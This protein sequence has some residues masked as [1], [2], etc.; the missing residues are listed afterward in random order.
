M[1]ELDLGKQV[2]PLPLGAWVVVVGAGL[3]IAVYTRRSTSTPDVPYI[4]TSGDPSVGTGPGWV[5]VPPPTTGPATQPITTNEDWARAAINHLIAKGY[6][7]NAAD[8]AI[9]G[10]IYGGSPGIRDYALLN[11]AIAALG[12]PP[13]P[14]PPATNNPPTA[15]PPSTTAPRQV[16][17]KDG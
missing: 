13:Y 12:P 6:E 4:D 17:T 1:P 3:G 9:R 8:Q 16:R 2:G 14:L 15:P 10:Y 7:P 5:A 11:V